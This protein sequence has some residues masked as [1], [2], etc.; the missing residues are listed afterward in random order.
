MRCPNRSGEA[1]GRASAFALL[2]TVS[3][4]G[5]V[6][7]QK[8][9][10]RLRGRWFQLAGAEQETSSSFRGIPVQFHESRTCVGLRACAP[11]S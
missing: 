10:L 11:N 5:L 6:L 3:D 1:S 4:P 2:F 8:V 7:W 9:V